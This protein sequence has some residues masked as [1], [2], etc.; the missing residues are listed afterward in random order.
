MPADIDEAAQAV[1][2]ADDDDRH[3]AH[4]RG[5]VV[6]DPGDLFAAPDVLPGPPEDAIPLSRGDGGIRV[7]G[8][9]ER[10]AALDLGGKHTMIE[11]AIG[12][13]HGADGARAGRGPSSCASLRR[14][15][16]APLQ[17]RL[18]E[19]VRLPP[20]QSRRAW[21]SSHRYSV[22]REYR[23]RRVVSLRSLTDG[24]R[25]RQR[26]SGRVGLVGHGRVG[27]RGARRSRRPRHRGIAGS[28][29]LHDGAWYLGRGGPC[30][31]ETSQRQSDSAFP[32]RMACSSPE[33]SGRSPER[34]KGI[35]HARCCSRETTTMAREW[36]APRANRA[37][38]R[39][40]SMRRGSAYRPALSRRPPPARPGGGADRHRS[41]PSTRARGRIGSGRPASAPR[42]P[43]CA[44]LPRT[45]PRSARGRGRP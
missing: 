11:R 7:P 41:A 18:S 33:S 16:A 21:E 36:A 31:A 24:W 25:A 4:C 39:P 17:C 3:I 26:R 42:A 14:G 8:C 13:V 10:C 12:I 20:G 34:E 32:R 19:A 44:P 9:G 2:V 43:G 37:P 15:R 30:Q 22:D 35:D 5:E 28:A 29:R 27:H 1:L 6:A 38:L 23:G 40:R 45:S